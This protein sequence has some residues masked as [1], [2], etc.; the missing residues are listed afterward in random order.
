[1]KDLQTG[2]ALAVYHVLAGKEP[3][4]AVNR[5]AVEEKDERYNNIR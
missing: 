4:N 5:K 3:I 2:A 1:M